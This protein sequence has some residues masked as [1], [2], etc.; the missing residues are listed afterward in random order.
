M[1]H[2]NQSMKIVDICHTLNI[3]RATFYRYVALSRK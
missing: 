2:E 3:S 1:L